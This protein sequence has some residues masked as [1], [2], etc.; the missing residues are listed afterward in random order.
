LTHK[1][2]E[3]SAAKT[4]VN[5]N[6]RVAVRLSDYDALRDAHEPL[7]ASGHPSGSGAQ[8]SQQGGRLA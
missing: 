7:L 6:L 4:D 3:S 8:L 5:R 1:R 2:T